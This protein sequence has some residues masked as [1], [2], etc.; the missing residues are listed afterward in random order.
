MCPGMN[1]T[2]LLEN[3]TEQCGREVAALTS[4]YQKARDVIY[5]THDPFILAFILRLRLAP[6]G[7][8]IYSGLLEITRFGVIRTRP[9]SGG[10]RKKSLGREERPGRLSST[11][12]FNIFRILVPPPPRQLER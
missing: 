6:S 11:L 12:K 4:A 1:R 8:R 10:A 7:I 2:A 9:R 5:F 3:T